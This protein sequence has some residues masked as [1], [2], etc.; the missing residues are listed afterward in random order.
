MLNWKKCKK[1]EQKK[2]DEVTDRCIERKDC[3]IGR[4]FCT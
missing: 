3:A 1:V 2:E 4:N